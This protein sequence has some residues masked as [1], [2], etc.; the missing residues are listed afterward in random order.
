MILVFIVERS[1]I[2]FY[3]GIKLCLKYYVAKNEK[4]VK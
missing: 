3:I 4:W 1:D 2:S